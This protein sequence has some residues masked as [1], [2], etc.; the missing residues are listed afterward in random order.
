MLGLCQQIGGDQRRVRTSVSYNDG[1]SWA[2]NPIN[3][4]NAEHFSLGH[5]HEDV[6]RSHDL[7]DLRHGLGAVRQRTDGMTFGSTAES[8]LSIESYGTFEPC[9]MFAL[10]IRLVHEATAES[11]SAATDFKM[12]GTA[13][14]GVVGLLSN[15][16]SMRDRTCVGTVVS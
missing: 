15:I 6:S 5:R 16:A 2:V 12:F 4:H 7:V 3:T 10:S 9:E 1:L 13:G 11:P 14:N 8:E